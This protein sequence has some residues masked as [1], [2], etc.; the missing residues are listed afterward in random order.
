[1]NCKVVITENKFI[2]SVMS[3]VFEY[4]YRC[5]K[6]DSFLVSR[7][8]EFRNQTWSDGR[9]CCFLSIITF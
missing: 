3:S 5:F 4:I 9:I 1:M 7:N 6:C 2:A 8:K